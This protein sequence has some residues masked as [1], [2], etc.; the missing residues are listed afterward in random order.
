MKGDFYYFK[1]L[2]SCGLPPWRVYM[3]L[4]DKLK[5]TLSDLEVIERCYRVDISDKTCY[6]YSMDELQ[7]LICSY[8]NYVDL[9]IESLN[10]WYHMA[11]RMKGEVEK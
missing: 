6:I 5:L 3:L 7:D 2:G 11:Q 1:E 8:D 4:K 9:K 10:I